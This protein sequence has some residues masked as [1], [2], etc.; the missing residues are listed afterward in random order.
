M[1]KAFNTIFAAVLKAKAQAQGMDV[2]LLCTGDDGQAKAQVLSLVTDV[3]FFRCGCGSGQESALSR[4]LTVLE[5]RRAY[6]QKLGTR[7][8]FKL[9]GVAAKATA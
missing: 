2:T 6:T 1:V 8:A 5:I 9:V 3:G 4:A 7:I